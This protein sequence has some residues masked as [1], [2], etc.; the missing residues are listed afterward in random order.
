MVENIIGSIAETNAN[1]SIREFREIGERIYNSFY[2][3]ISRGSNSSDQHFL[4]Q[5]LKDFYT[6]YQN[7]LRAM[8]SR[9]LECSLVHKNLDA[10]LASNAMGNSVDLG[11]LIKDNMGEIM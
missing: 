5:H 2:Q 1:Q 10:I 7:L 11:G 9:D 8:H 3:L 6:L 4:N